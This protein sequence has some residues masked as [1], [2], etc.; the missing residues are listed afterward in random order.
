MPGPEPYQF[1]ATYHDEI[2]RLENEARMQAAAS[3]ELSA[4]LAFLLTNTASSSSGEGGIYS[5]QIPY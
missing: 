5:Y 3:Y 1:P 4:Y 2:K